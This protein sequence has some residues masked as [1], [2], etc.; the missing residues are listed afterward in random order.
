MESFD[1]ESPTIKMLQK[2]IRHHMT[3]NLFKWSVLGEEHVPGEAQTA[4]LFKAL[5]ATNEPHQLEPKTWRSWFADKKRRPYG[6]TISALDTYAGHDRLK[7]PWHLSHTPL[8]TDFFKTLSEGGL[9]ARIMEPITTR[10]VT[11]TL[12]QR[13]LDYEPLSRIHLH[14]DA[15]EAV[16]LVE[17]NGP[18]SWELVKATA[19]DRVLGVLHS[20]W[21]PRGGAV[22][23]DLSSDLELRLRSADPVGQSDIHEYY[24]RWKHGLYESD[25]RK[26]PRPQWSTIGVDVDTS[27]RQ[28]HRL[29]LAMASD[30]DFLVADRLEVWALDLVSAALAMK[31]LAWTDRYATFGGRISPE[32]IY[33]RAYDAIFF[34]D[35]SDAVTVNAIAAAFEA[36]GTDLTEVAADNLYRAREYYWYLMGKLH[37]DRESLLTLILRCWAARPVKCHG[38]YSTVDRLPPAVEARRPNS[39]LPRA[40]P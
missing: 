16:A 32:M 2:T 29:L 9:V 25:L 1:S 27:P 31:A 37:V 35:E 38:S 12:I 28:I 7:K 24:R 20:R 17:A 30:A 21:S 8:R 6:R 39:T 10:K 5:D 18:A 22:Y 19:A 26:P 4:T 11:S 14:V 3:V 33:W 15:L 36:H 40:A 34:S 13:G 23:A